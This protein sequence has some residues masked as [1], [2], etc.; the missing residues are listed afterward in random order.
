MSDGT[1]INAALR[2]MDFGHDDHVAHGFRAMARTMIAER[3]QG[4]PDA[5]VEAQ[6]GH[7]KS[8]A[9]GQRR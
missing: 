2:R 3:M 7:G 5:M 6:L 9:T 8:G 4:I 1:T